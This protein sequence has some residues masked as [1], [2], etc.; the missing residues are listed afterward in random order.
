MIGVVIWS[1]FQDGTALIWCE[2]HGDLAFCR[3]ELG[4]GYVDLSSGDLVTFELGCESFQRLA[5]NPR[6]LAEGMYQG[7]SSHL[8]AHAADKAVPE[9]SE[10]F[11]QRGA[12]IVPLSRRVSV[13]RKCAV[14]EGRL[15]AG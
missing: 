7:I 10:R 8:S 14:S 3:Q 6:L 4:N 11:E 2:D 13:M 12:E 9:R 1:D 5:Y 15:S